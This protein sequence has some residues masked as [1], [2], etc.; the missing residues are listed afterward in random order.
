MHPAQGVVECCFDLG[1]IHLAWQSHRLG[2]ITRRDEEDV[3]IVD[4]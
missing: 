2:Q 3:D 1:V 4:A